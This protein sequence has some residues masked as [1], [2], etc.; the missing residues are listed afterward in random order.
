MKPR[1]HLVL[2]ALALLLAPLALAENP[3]LHAQSDEPAVAKFK[4]VEWNE[5]FDQ[6]E[7]AWSARVTTRRVATASWGAFFKISFDQI[8]TKAPHP[9]ELRPLYFFTTENEI[10][11]LNEEKPDEAIRQLAAQPK[12]PKFEPRDLYG[13]S[14]GA[15]QVADDGTSSSKLA[16]K[17]DRSTYQWTHHSGHFTTVAWQRGVGLVEFAQGYGARR[18]GFRLKR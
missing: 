2:A 9:R 13:L 15:R 10:V 18:D 16:V 3:F 11:L 1:F 5:E 14:K 6:D 12:P 8:A 7:Y 17:G 4:G